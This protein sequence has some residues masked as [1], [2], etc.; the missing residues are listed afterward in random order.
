MKRALILL[1]ILGLAAC[2]LVPA[3]ASAQTPSPQAI[4]CVD[5]ANSY[6]VVPATAVGWQ[7]NLKTG[8]TANGVFLQGLVLQHEFSTLPLG[9]GLY[10]GLGA[11]NANQT[12]YQGCLG[13]SVTSWGM[14]CGGIQRATFPDGA[15]A[16]Q[17]M[18]TFAGQLTYGGSP[19]YVR[20][21]AG[22]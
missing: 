21:K 20:A 11:S 18:A 7:V 6:C 13:V 5:K 16:W 4:G 19:S 15:T 9:L 14:L 1:S 2:L 3:V 12:S 10:V 17:G 22:Q 8:G